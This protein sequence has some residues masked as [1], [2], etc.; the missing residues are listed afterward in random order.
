M[1]GEVGIEP[2]NAGIRIQC[3]TTWRLPIITNYCLANSLWNADPTLPHKIIQLTPIPYYM[4]GEVGIEPTNA[5]IKTQCLNR[6]ATPHNFKLT[7]SSKILHR[8]PV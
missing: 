5:E 2:T 1:A 6:L 3:L 4:A 7:S 8:M